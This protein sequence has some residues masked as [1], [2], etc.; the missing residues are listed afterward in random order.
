MTETTEL[1]VYNEVAATVAQAKAE[2]EILVFDYENKEGAKEAKSHIAKLR[3][4][5]TKIAAV[6]KEA[7]A[8]A[9]AFGRRLDAKKNELTG[10]VDG[11]INVHKEPLDKIE[12]EKTRIAFKKAEEVR[13]ERERIEAEK[14]AELDRREAEIR[15]KEQ[16]IIEAE[17]KIAREKADAD[18]QEREKRI[19]EESAERA[20]KEAE[21]RLER[22]KREA[23]A[24]AKAKI[25]KMKADAAAKE[26]AEKRRKEAEAEAERKRIANKE[27]RQKIE[28]AIL[29]AL[30]AELLDHKLA[31]KVWDLLKDNKIPNVTINY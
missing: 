9:L 28:G 19:A 24:K 3:K 17:E 23:E 5:K 16:A 4:V 21:E 25:E 18:R 29:K 15:A 2:N 26:L 13:I 1:A 12:A 10:E 11:M 8:D 27:H 31:F 6:H 20:R 14:Q 22:E 7:K 30:S